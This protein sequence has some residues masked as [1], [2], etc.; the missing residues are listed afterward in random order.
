MVSG[1]QF[2]DDDD[3][4]ESYWAR[5]KRQDN[6]NDTIEKPIM[7]E[8][9]DNVKYMNVLDLGCGG[10]DFGELLLSM[11]CQTYTGIDASS[12]MIE[13][14]GKTISSPQATVIHS[15]IAT[16]DYVPQ[17]YHLIVSRLTLHYVENLENL[18]IRLRSALKQDGKIIFSVEHPVLT[19]NNMATEKLDTFRDVWTVK[20]Y[21]QTGAR[22]VWWMG[23]QV[24]KYHRTIEDYFKLFS[25]TG[26][27]LVNL[28]ESKP[29]P[30]N[31]SNPH[32]YERRLNV[33]LFLFFVLKTTPNK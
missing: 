9:V 17:Q 28:R 12:K 14:A 3:I 16:Y 22:D 15:D 30:Q 5:R 31:F 25:D 1:P 6:P 13:R 23:K 27:Q 2:F 20:D 19:S 24:T 21:F 29:S 7:L 4:F 26:F 32:E 10:G 33:P 11:G 8:L 18:F